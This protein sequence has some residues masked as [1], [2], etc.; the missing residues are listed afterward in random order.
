MSRIESR[1]NPIHGQLQQQSV[2]S[3]EPAIADERAGGITRCAPLMSRNV[4]EVQV[5][6]SQLPS[7]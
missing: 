2:E 3:A 4:S 5:R 7:P 1:E 6:R